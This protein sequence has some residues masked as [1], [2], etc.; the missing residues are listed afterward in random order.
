[1]AEVLRL[2]TENLVLEIQRSLDFFSA[3]SAE[4]EVHRVFLAGGTCRVP[5]LVS[6]VEE[7]LGIPTEIMNPFRGLQYPEKLFDP[8]YLD[9][10]GP[11][12]SVATGLALRRADER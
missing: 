9:Y 5:G 7:R 3:T 2:T 11:V 10:M 4:E 8:D 1:M 6:A 12:A